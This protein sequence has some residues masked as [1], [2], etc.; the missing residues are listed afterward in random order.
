VLYLALDACDPGLMVDLARAGHCPNIARLLSD[1]AS[2]ETVAPYGTFVG[3]T[4]M[5]IATGLEVGHHR[6]YT[7][8]QL[9][10]GRYDLRHTSPREAHGTPF[11]ETLSARGR[12]L[13]VLDVPHSQAPDALNGAFLKEWGCHDRH[14]GTASFPPDLVD[15][16]DELT[17]GH[18]YGAMPPP[19]GED[20]FAPC[21]YVV[22]AG[23]RRTLDEE[24]QVYD[25]IVRG[26]D[27]K[28]QASL[29]LLAQG[30]W[31]LFVSVIGESHCVGHQLWHVHDVDHPRHDP[32]ARRLLG[33]PLVEVYARLD[34]VVGEHIAGAGPDATCYVHL[35]HGMGPHYDGDHVLDEVLRRI[36]DA[37]RTSVPTGWRTRLAHRALERMPASLRCRARPLAAAAL[38][39]RISSAPPVP[40][41]PPGPRPDRRW[42]Q[43]P[44]NT[45]VG[46]IRFNVVGREPAGLVPAGPEVDRL[47]AIVTKGL[48]EVINVDTG[49]PVVQRVI[50]TEEVLERSDGDT[51]PDLFVEWDRSA[52]IERVW[53][54]TIGTVYVPYEHWRTGDHHDRGLLLAAGPGIAPGRRA[55]SMGLTEIAPTLAA[56]VGEEL[57]AVDGRPRLDLV[58]AGSPAPSAPLATEEPARTGAHRRRRRPLWQRGR[59]AS[60][61]NRR[62]IDADRRMAEG[63]LDLAQAAVVRAEAAQADLEREAAALRLRVHHLDR[64]NLVWTTMRWL[65]AITVDEDRL[66]T[67]VTPTHERP[68][69]LAT[70]IE[71]VRAQT[72]R[73]WEMIVVDDGSDT[74]KSVVAE[75]GDD[76]VRALQIEHRGATAARNVALDA[77]TGS[78]ITYLDDDN[79]LDPG[80]LKAVAWAFQTHPETEVLYGARMI[81]DHDRVHEQGEGGWPWLQFNE[82]DRDRLEQGNLADMGA[83]AHLANLPDA[84]FDERLREYGDWDLLL[85]LTEDRTP[86]ELPAIALYYHTEGEGQGPRLT[87][88]HP[89][90]VMLVREKW[91]ARRAARD[92]GRPPTG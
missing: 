49:R 31:D 16:L 26:L 46:A 88:T 62:R 80:W 12:R 32:T 70:A 55:D 24:R 10:E 21:D 3:S 34:A 66:I 74:A 65:D 1:G 85:A 81:D 30:A 47:A 63:A 57:E 83:L 58:G 4:W 60:A 27:A 20:Q 40:A 68:R 15:D 82:F 7:W 89:G 56:A 41:S 71:S 91:A 8:V 90:D 86:L 67:V 22:R 25:L 48:L 69:M 78:V 54:P 17:G 76:R 43:V 64:A 5:T 37:D 33:D 28:R 51:F 42:F 11:W 87:G 44:N 50:P 13:A 79:R 39:H 6:Y 92:A 18:P 77:A 23:P 53:S 61:S 59:A 75:I 36:D 45:V 84:R 29:H 73:R 72:Y 2:V 9:A 38:R 52:P 19:R 35:S 14:H